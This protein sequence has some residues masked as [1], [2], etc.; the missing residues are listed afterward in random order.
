MEIELNLDSETFRK[1]QFIA[2]VKGMSL[3]KTVEDLIERLYREELAHER[4]LNAL[5]KLKRVTQT[6]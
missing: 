2:K 4:F 1:L 3:T 5:R 6:L